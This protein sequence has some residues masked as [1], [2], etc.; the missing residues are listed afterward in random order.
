M[1]EIY[2]RL[3]TGL[4]QTI[5]AHLILD[6]LQR[7][8]GRLRTVTSD[9]MEARLFLTRG[10]PLQ[11]GELLR[12]QCGKTLRVEGAEEPVIS[13]SCDDWSLFSRACYHLGNRHVKVEIG[14]RRLRISA[15]HVLEEMLQLLGLETKRENAIFMPEAGAY[16][17]GHHHH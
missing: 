17:H 9:G 3:G 10:K 12:S 6:H 16:S 13:A 11:V 7:D 4:D 1:I 8:K 15:D 5:D 2:E 14:Q